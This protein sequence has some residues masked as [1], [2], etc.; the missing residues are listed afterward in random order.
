MPPVMKTPM[1]KA[2]VGTAAAATMMAGSITPA[3]ADRRDRGIDTGDIIA[4]ALILGGIA[5]IA[6]SGG[7]ND[8]YRDRY[9]D[10]YDRRYDRRYDNRDGYY[11]GGSA[12]DAVERCIRTA[13]REAYRRGFRRVDVTDV[14]DV[15]RRRDGYRVKGRIAVDTGYRGGRYGNGWGGD[16]RGYRNDMRGWDSGRFECRTDRGRVNYLDFDNIRGLR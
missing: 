8:R 6:T 2:V 5:A 12:R 11:R 13:E 7:R 1:M 9:D 10:R 16:Y 3:F 4:G 15:D 14:R